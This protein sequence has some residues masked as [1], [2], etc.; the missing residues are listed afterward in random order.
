MEQALLAAMPALS[1]P[2]TATEVSALMRHYLADRIE[3]KRV[4]LAGPSP[5]RVPKRTAGAF[6]SP[7][8]Q[9]ILPTRTTARRTFSARV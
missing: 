2:A 6:A 7:G 5:K 8:F 1:G 9:P 4:D 3:M